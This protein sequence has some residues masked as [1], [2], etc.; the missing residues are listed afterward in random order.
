MYSKCVYRTIAKQWRRFK[1]SSSAHEAAC[2]L[3][4]AGLILSL[5][6]R[7]ERNV[8]TYSDFHR[9]FCQELEERVAQHLD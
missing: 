8:I 7:L 1:L 9:T 3:V 6:D 4:V 5:E 2:K